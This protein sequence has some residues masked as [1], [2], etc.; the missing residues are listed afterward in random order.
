MMFFNFVFGETLKEVFG[1]TFK[2]VFGKTLIEVFG[3]TLCLQCKLWFWSYL[4]TSFEWHK[5]LCS[6]KEQFVMINVTL[7]YQCDVSLLLISRKEHFLNC[8]YF[9]LGKHFWST[10]LV[11]DS[12]SE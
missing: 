3:E 2:E 4:S 11:S 7:I 12:N 1:E 9:R 8:D 5:W 6:E 10:I